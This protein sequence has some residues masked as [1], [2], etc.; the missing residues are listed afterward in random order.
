MTQAID[1]AN[2]GTPDSFRAA[3]DIANQVPLDSA[4]RGEA[5]YEINNWGN[6]LLSQ[7]E[8]QVSVNPDAAISIATKIPPYS[9]FYNQAQEL[10]RNLSNAQLLQPAPSDP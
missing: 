7:A 1:T 6:Q 10:I 8:S 9:T 2:Q 3:M 5:D 4:E